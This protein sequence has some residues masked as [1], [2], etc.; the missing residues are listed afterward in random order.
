MKR[1]KHVLYQLSNVYQCVHVIIYQTV[2][3]QCIFC[4]SEPQMSFIENRVSSD[5]IKLIS[6]LPLE[7][8]ILPP[9]PIVFSKHC[10][11][12]LCGVLLYYIIEWFIYFTFSL[13]QS[14]AFSAVWSEFWMGLVLL[15]YNIIIMHTWCIH[16]TFLKINGTRLIF[17]FY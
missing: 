12:Y 2:L 16:N 14:A 6:S 13:P 15:S 8:S 11:L 5:I 4:N 17:T 3:M 10:L 1:R 9:H 7:E